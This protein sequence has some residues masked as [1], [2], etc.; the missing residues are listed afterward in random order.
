MISLF[1]STSKSMAICGEMVPARGRCGD[2]VAA[3][4]ASLRLCG[5]MIGGGADGVR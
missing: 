4:G 5:F 3:L 2:K 1:Q